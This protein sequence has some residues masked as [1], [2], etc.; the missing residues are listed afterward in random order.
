MLDPLYFNRM[1]ANQA[2]GGRDE[3]PDEPALF[4]ILHRIADTNQVNPINHAR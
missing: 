3:L 1:L 4:S 2:K